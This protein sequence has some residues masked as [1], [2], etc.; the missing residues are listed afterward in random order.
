M[1]ALKHKGSGLRVNPNPCPQQGPF[2]FAFGFELIE[3]LNNS[4]I[5]GDKQLF[6]VSSIT[7]EMDPVTPTPITGGAAIGV[8]ATAC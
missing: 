2:T 5:I 1:A 3:L 7:P 8:T 4:L 6:T